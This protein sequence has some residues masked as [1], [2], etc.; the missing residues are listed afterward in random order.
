MGGLE[1]NSDS[2][3]F[4]EVVLNN[5]ILKQQ[6]KPSL[7]HQISGSEMAY[8]KKICQKSRAIQAAHLFQ[9]APKMWNFQEKKHMNF[10]RSNFSLQ[11]QG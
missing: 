7:N 9:P 6:L 3:V 5:A 11:F 4:E 1:S 10:I 8:T 2:Q